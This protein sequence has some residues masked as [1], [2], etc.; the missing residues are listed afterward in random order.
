MDFRRLFIYCMSNEAEAR[1]RF[2][3]SGYL[4]QVLLG[5]VI[6]WHNEAALSLAAL[7]GL[8]AAW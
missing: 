5:A 1:R 4:D 2:R 3:S 7:G 6:Y 8:G